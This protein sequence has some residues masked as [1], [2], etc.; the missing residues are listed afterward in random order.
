MGTDLAV[1]SEHLSIKDILHINI[2]LEGCRV[3]A[4]EKSQE[5][6]QPFRGITFLQH[7]ALISCHTLLSPGGHA[8]D[9]D[10]ITAGGQDGISFVNPIGEIFLHPLAG[11]IYYFFLLVLLVLLFPSSFLL[12]LFCSLSSCLCFLC[13]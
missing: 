6:M 11:I 13:I 2:S 3:T 8:S 7:I 10:D 4:G 5:Q 1:S 9:S 12:P